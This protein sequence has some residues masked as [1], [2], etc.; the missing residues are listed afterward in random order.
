MFSTPLGKIDGLLENGP[1]V[2]DFGH[3]LPFSIYIYI[4][5][6]HSNAH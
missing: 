1:F 3:I 4:Y 6:N 2:D 5:I